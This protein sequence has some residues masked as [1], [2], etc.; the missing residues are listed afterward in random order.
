MPSMT[1]RVNIKAPVAIRTITP[2]IYGTCNNIIMTTGDILK[3]ICKKAIVEEILPDGS[4]VRLNMRNYYTDN[5]AGLDAKKVEL[6]KKDEEKIPENTAEE[7][8]NEDNTSNEKPLAEIAIE[9]DAPSAF[10]TGMS[11]VE[12]T[13][14]APEAP[15]EEAQVVE[16]DVTTSCNTEV[17]SVAVEHTSVE[18][19]SSD[20]NLDTTKTSSESVTTAAEKPATTKKN[21]TKKKTN[22]SNK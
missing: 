20:A 17:E 14:K 12:E 1:K 16:T 21:S 6:A 9:C 19:A 2:P 10:V 7:A 5:G 8:V 11:I 3:C 13:D 15:S 22:S 4:T 18:N